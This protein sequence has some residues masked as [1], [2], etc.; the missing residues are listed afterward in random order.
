MRGK[1]RSAEWD[2]DVEGLYRQAQTLALYSFLFYFWGEG[3]S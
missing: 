2:L 1:G 3:G